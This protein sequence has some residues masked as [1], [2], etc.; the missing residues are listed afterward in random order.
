VPADGTVRESSI[1]ETS[2]PRSARI[3]PGTWP[4]S[5]R[6]GD[7]DLNVFLHVSNVRRALNALRV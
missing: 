2:G 5:V 1:A 7:H 4:P 3:Y 6:N